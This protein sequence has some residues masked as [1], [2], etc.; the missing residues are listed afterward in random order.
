M[1]VSSVMRA[2]SCV[3]S[4]VFQT[5]L[6]RSDVHLFQFLARTCSRCR[7]KCTCEVIYIYIYLCVASAVG[8]WEKCPVKNSNIRGVCCFGIVCF[9]HVFHFIWEDNILFCNT[10][11][12][13][14]V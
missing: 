3:E 11:A 10:K 9:T 1:E 7:L 4:S 8:G 14:S 2:A 6:N 13:A 5:N 12:Q